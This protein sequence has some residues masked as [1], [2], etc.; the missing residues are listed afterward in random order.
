[1]K[2]DP[3][4]IADLNQR[5]KEEL[6]AINQY[7]IHRAIMANWNY[8]GFVAYIQERL[9]D[10]TNHYNLL[11]DRICFLGGI[12]DT[13]V[14]NVNPADMVDGMLVNDL[15]AEE[16]AIVKYN[17]TIR[18]CMEV[19][20]DDTRRLIETILADETDHAKDIEANLVQLNQMGI[21]NY[22]SLQVGGQ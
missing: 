12:P 5:I 14:V 8:A 2:G 18:L 3:R 11:L 9:N 16:D 7:S 1:M 6:G 22:L 4:I 20:D 19:G 15:A 17:Q 10:E 21:Q 13:G